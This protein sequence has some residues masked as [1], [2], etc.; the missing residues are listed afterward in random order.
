MTNMEKPIS[1]FVDSLDLL[2]DPFAEHKISGAVNSYIKEKGIK[3]LPAK[4]MAE[5]MA[6]DFVQNYQNKE[7]SW[8]TY[9]GPMMVWNNDDGTATES[10]SIKLVSQEILKYWKERSKQAEHPILKLR[11]ADLVWDFSKHI[12]EKSPHF[13][14]AHTIID[15]TIA[16]ATQGRHKY[17]TDVITKL[18]RALLVALSINNPE[19]VEKLRDTIIQYEDSIAEDTKPGLWGFTFDL[20]LK[21][22]K[23]PI[24]EEIKQKIIQDL[25]DRLSKLSDTSNKNNIDPWAAEAAALRLAG[26][27]RILNQKESIRNVLL[28]FGTAFEVASED[29]SALQASAWLQRVHSVYID[30]GLREEAEKIAIK[31]KEIGPKVN[32]EMKPISHEMKISHEDMQKYIN[33]IIDD[34]LESTFVR[35]AIHYIPKK[36]QVENQLKD[37]AQKAPISYL[38]PRQIQDHQGRPIAFIGSLEDDLI[39]NIVHLSAQNMG[40]SVVFLRRV[41]EEFISRFKLTPKNVVDYLYQSPVFDEDKRELILNGI[42]AYLKN[43]HLTTIHLLIPQIESAFRKFVEH[44]GGPVLKPSRGGGMHLKTLDELLRDQRVINVFGEDMSLYFRILLTDQRGWNLRNDVCHGISPAATFQ[45][46]ISD[47]VIHT[48]LCLALVRDKE[49]NNSDAEQAN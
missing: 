36:D 3:D 32:E 34:D 49:G 27:Y 6:F 35:I 43:D 18:E 45:V 46:N 7:T 20:L 42:R 9:Y 30:Y 16:I 40:I 25:E 31:L 48:L 17:E 8:G 23:I 44:T 5:A 28:K 14:L 12:T 11:Y 26:Y 41:M 1:G 13:S 39:G 4:L 37:L 38:V 22:K 47:R 10:P 21:N 15:N 33:S 19:R 2:N 24:S 29:A